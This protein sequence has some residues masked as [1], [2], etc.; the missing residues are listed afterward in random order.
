MRLANL[1]LVAVA[2]LAAAFLGG[3]CAGFIGVL[4]GSPVLGAALGLPAMVVAAHLAGR[5]ISRRENAP[6]KREL[7]AGTVLYAVMSLLAAISLRQPHVMIFA[8][9]G[10]C[11]NGF[12]LSRAAVAAR[13]GRPA[14][15]SQRTA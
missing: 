1:C 15:E 5:W 9:A 14:A 3:F 4:A 7:I 12:V 10:A 13:A 2:A 11:T 6:T 8:L